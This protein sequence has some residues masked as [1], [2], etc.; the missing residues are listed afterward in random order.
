MPSQRRFLHYLLAICFSRAGNVS[1]GDLCSRRG[2]FIFT[3]CSVADL[4]E[5][6][7]P[8]IRMNKQLTLNDNNTDEDGTQS[9][10]T[11]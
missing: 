3:R 5:G 7:D 2:K 6:H 11:P 1:E 4:F 8:K 10:M 9:E